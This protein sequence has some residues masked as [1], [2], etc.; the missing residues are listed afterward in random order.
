[1]KFI[2]NLCMTEHRNH[3]KYIKTKILRNKIKNK[4]MTEEIEFILDSTPK[5]P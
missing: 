3:S 1:M 4:I 5:N 2:E